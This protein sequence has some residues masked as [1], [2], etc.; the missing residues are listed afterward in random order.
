MKEN[1]PDAAG[2]RSHAC[3]ELLGDVLICG[4]LP[5]PLHERLY[6]PGQRLGNLLIDL[7]AARHRNFAPPSV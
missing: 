2:E 4:V 1:R 5:T 3:R 6:V 7:R